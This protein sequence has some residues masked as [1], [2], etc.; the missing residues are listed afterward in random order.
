MSYVSHWEILYPSEYPEDFEAS[1][2]SIVQNENKKIPTDSS[3]KFLVVVP[4]REPGGYIYHRAAPAGTMI[5]ELFDSIFKDFRQDKSGIMRV[6]YDL[7]HNKVKIS[8]YDFQSKDTTTF[9]ENLGGQFCPFFPG[10]SYFFTDH[11]KTYRVTPNDGCNFRWLK[12]HLDVK[13]RDWFILRCDYQ[14]SE[15]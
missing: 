1:A 13:E 14:T 7:I 9:R 5:S 12:S 3:K 15:S 4:T 6:K 11:G 8:Y 10:T 2:D